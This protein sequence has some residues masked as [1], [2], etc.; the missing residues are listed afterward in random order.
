MAPAHLFQSALA[1]TDLEQF[2]REV[3][4]TSEALREPLSD[5]DA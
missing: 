1:L 4:Q 5:A 3:R 2:Y